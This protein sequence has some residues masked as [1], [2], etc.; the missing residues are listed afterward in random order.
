MFEHTNTNMFK[1]SGEKREMPVNIPNKC[2]GGGDKGYMVNLGYFY[3]RVKINS[4]WLVA[5]LVANV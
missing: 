2:L 3:N 1:K 5:L 4:K